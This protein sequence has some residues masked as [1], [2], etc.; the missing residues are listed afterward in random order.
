MDVVPG[1]LDLR[2]QRTRW[3]NCSPQ[4]TL[5]FNWCLVMAPD[6][7][8]DYVVIYELTHLQERNHTRR[9]WDI[10]WQFDPEYETH[11]E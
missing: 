8:I 10:V 5:S 3:A 9:F 4:L 1:K 2:N 6:N 11:F 7:V